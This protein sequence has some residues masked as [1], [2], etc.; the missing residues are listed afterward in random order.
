MNKFRKVSLAL[1]L[2]V[3][4]S[5]AQ[6]ALAGQN[7]PAMADGEVKK[8]DKDAGKITIK[9]GELKDL[10]MMPMTMVFK[11]KEPAMLDKVSPGAKV[12]FSAEKV[13]GAVT[14]TALEVVK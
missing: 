1:M 9:H 8:I 4:G 11:V 12:R 3:A 14:V 13:Q 10:G 7:S 5:T 2:A 6:V